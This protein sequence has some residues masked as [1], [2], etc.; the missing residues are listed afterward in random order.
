MNEDTAGKIEAEAV[1]ADGPTL[2]KI[3]PSI[4]K[5]KTPNKIGK[6]DRATAS[7]TKKARAKRGRGSQR[8]KRQ[9]RPYPGKTLEE[10]IKVV[11][12]IKTQNAGNPWPSDEIAKAIKIQ[13]RSSNLGEVIRSSNLYGLVSGTY[14]AVTVVLTDLGRRLAYPQND[15]ELKQARQEALFSV[16]LFNRVILH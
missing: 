14:R 13:T 9:A 5:Q 15:Q 4:E 7:G 10:C 1:L 11:E 16:D 6:R 3:R 12:A 2:A 8:S